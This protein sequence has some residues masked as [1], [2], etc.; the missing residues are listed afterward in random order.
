MII[1]QAKLAR[2]LGVHRSAVSRW[3]RGD[4]APRQPTIDAILAFCRRWDPDVTYE[5]LFGRSQATGDGP[6]TG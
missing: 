3:I 6:D 2:H 4:H 5:Q 1:P